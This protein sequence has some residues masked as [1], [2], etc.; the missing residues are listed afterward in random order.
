[1]TKSYLEI[2]GEQSLN[3]TDISSTNYQE[4]NDIENSLVKKVNANND[5]FVRTV[6]QQSEQLVNW[7]NTAIGQGERNV[8]ALSNI[9][10]YSKSLKKSVEDFNTWRDN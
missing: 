7:Y 9:A 4:F 6:E 5:E 3:S 2:L 10:Q 8:T 1:M